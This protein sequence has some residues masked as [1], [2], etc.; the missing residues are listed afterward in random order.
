MVASANYQETTPRQAHAAGSARAPRP[1]PPR[2][3]SAEAGAA[4]E[5]VAAGAQRE[6]LTRHRPHIGTF[7]LATVVRGLRRRIEEL[8]G[9]G[10]V[11]L[12]PGQA[13]RQP[14][15]P[16]GAGGGLEVAQVL[17]EA[18]QRCVGVLGSLGLE[19][20]HSHV[21][22]PG[23]ELGR[24]EQ[25]QQRRAR[26]ALPAPELAERERQRDVVVGTL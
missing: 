21:G 9:E 22:P 4:E 7:K 17:A 3:A 12:A 8:G 6:I 5:L 20:G 16:V 11:L 2:R 18:L 14:E 15:R 19:E 24:A 13:G 23:A 25:G 1:S 26:L 10:E